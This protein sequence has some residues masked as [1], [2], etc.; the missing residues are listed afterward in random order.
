M[1]GRMMGDMTETWNW[2]GGRV[3]EA[4]PA[5]AAAVA[6]LIAEPAVAAAWDRP[7]ALPDFGV[8]G[9]AAH[10]AHQELV[11]PELLAAPE[12]SQPVISLREY[13]LDRV[14]WLD[15][16]VDGAV[17]I[18]IRKAGEAT[19]ADGHAT[20]H[21]RVREAAGGSHR[22]WRPLPPAGRSGR[23]PGATGPSNSTT[24]CSPG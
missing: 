11:L 15:A 1:T 5:A 4:F 13:Y 6:E 14:T 18:R 9:L 17:D 20:P 2:R 10:T 22:I 3:R 16:G 19:G 7:S 8:G 21:A 12:P 23:P 24:S